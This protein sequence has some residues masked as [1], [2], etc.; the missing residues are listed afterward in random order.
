[1]QEQYPFIA[2]NDKDRASML[3]SMGLNSIDEL[4]EDVPKNYLIQ[5]KLD[6]LTLL[7]NG[8]CKIIFAIKLN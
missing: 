7:K 3:Y 4:F 8:N 2:H 6:C 5:N 1:M